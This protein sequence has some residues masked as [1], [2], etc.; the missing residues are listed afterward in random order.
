MD[1]PLGAPWEISDSLLIPQRELI[2]PF[3]CGAPLDEPPLL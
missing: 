3:K 1:G 2:N